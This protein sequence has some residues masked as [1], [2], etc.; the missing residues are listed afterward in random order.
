MMTGLIIDHNTS[1]IKAVTGYVNIPS[2]SIGTLGAIKFPAGDGTVGQALITDGV[3]NLTWGSPTTKLSTDAAPKLGAD[4]DVN[5]KQ[6]ISTGDLVLF[7][8]GKI[9]LGTIRFPNVDGAPNQVLKTDG[10]GS[11]SWMTALT[12]VQAD[13]APKLGGNLDVNGKTIT[14]TTN[15]TLTTVMGGRVI[16]NGMRFPTVDGSAGQVLKTDGAGSLY[17]DADAVGGGTGTANVVSDTTPKLGGNLDVNGHSIVSVNNENIILTPNGTGRVVIKGL[18]F[19]AADGTAG[20]VIGTDGAGNLVW[21]SGGGSM[22]LD[23]AP[24]LGGNLD[25]N[26]K[27]IMSSTGTVAIDSNVSIIGDTNCRSGLYVVKGETADGVL[28]SLPALPIPTDTTW[29]F[30]VQIAARRV[31]GDDESAAYKIEGAID[32]NAGIVSLV[33]EPMTILMAEDQNAW[34]AVVEAENTGNALVIKVTG[35]AGKIIRWVAFVHTAEVSG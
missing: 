2:L 19:P 15:I 10:A 8:T 32:N 7:P 27:T 25:V 13:S 3:G 30:I 35:E 26:N 34:N 12:S 5:G 29:S 9:V 14:S 28:T 16:M 31:D 21:T 1:E 18:A 11:L 20:Q 4:L 22:E 23:S 6:I 33:G 17:W 24:T